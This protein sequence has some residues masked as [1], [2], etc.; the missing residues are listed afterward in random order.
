MRGSFYILTSVFRSILVVAASNFVVAR[1][2]VRNQSANA[3][4]CSKNEGGATNAPGAFKVKV[5]A[6]SLSA[7]LGRN[8]GKT[9]LLNGS[10][11]PSARR[12]RDSVTSLATCHASRVPLP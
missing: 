12:S 6:I 4:E 8:E 7:V 2:V 3:F 11:V 1:I 10:N 5:E 9:E